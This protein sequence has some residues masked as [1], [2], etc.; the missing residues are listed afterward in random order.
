MSLFSELKR[1]NVI[2]VGAAYIVTAWLV[3]Q[4]VETLFPIYGLSDSAIRFVVSALGVGFLPVLV[5][6]WALEITPDGL[7]WEK[8]VDR[9]QSITSQTGKTLDRVI[10]AVLAVA[11]GFFAFDKFVLSES[12][13]AKIAESAREEGRTAALLDSYGDRS[14]AVLPFVDMS[15]AKDQEYM[16]DGIA[17]EILNLLARIRELR[18][19]SRSSAFSFKNKEVDIPSIGEQLNAAFVLEGSVRTA[20]DQVRITAQLIDAQ[21]DTHLWSHTYD[22]QLQDIF[23]IQDDIAAAVVDELKV[24]LLDEA[25]RSQ[26]IDTEAYALVLQARYYWNRRAPG[27]EQKVLEMYQE[28]VE[29]APAYAPAWA[30][31]SVAYAVHARKGRMDLEEGQ[32]LAH[33]AAEKA[34]E[35]D[36]DS[37]HALVRMAQA[38]ARA[39]DEDG[40]L[41]ALRR[42]YELDPDDP[43]VLGVMSVHL[44]TTGKFDEAVKHIERAEKVDP[45]GAIWPANK[46]IALTMA[47]RFDEAKHAYARALELNGNLDTYNRAMADIYIFKGE[48]DKALEALRDVPIEREWTI[49]HAIAE[50]GVGNVDKTEEIIE[51]IKDTAGPFLATS[52]AAIYAARGENDL[53]FEW[54]ARNETV[55]RVGIE[56][57]MFYKKLRDDPRWLPYLESLD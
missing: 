46:G 50:Y 21:T 54:L 9:S 18:V 24:T 38:L 26:P 43:L 1:R 52:M 29:L 51:Y 56:F 20:G 49:R 17:E 22:R 27:D 7:K 31:L 19:I 28:A 6:A 53:A 12:R 14:I 32:R 2:R 30:G 48:Y 33:E 16:S 45:L 23:Q 41:A 15:P 35:L 36:P 8:N 10:I 42:A 39:S 47:E 3:V 44:R 25:P 5:L 13:E 57:N 34:V 37:T 11:V 4:V 55:P 40:S